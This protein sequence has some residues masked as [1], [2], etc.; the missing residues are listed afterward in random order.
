MK[1]IDAENLSERKVIYNSNPEIQITNSFGQIS[2][3][4]DNSPRFED[5]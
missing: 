3:N 4:S 1:S 2:T 5:N